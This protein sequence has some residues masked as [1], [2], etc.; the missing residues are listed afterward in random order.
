M[1]R[2]YGPVYGLRMAHSESV[3]GSGI[4]TKMNFFACQPV[5]IP[6]NGY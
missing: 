4:S 5:F 6:L 2:V 1:I 3:I